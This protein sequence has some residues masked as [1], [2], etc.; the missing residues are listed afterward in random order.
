MQADAGPVSGSQ[1]RSRGNAQDAVQAEVRDVQSRGHGPVGGRPRAGR[2]GGAR[3]GQKVQGQGFQH[4]HRRVL[5]LRQGQALL[6][7]R[8]QQLVS[9]H[10]SHIFE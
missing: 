5:P 2:Q 1:L 9:S 4:L 6:P 3:G 10:L 8:V 7:N